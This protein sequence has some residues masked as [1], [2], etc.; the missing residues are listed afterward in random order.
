MGGKGNAKSPREIER[1]CLSFYKCA[2]KK[3]LSPVHP[4]I[5]TIQIQT[6]LLPY[7]LKAKNTTA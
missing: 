5:P 4:S 2:H 6:S 7:T 1:K 3:C